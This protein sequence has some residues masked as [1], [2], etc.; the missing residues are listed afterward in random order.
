MCVNILPEVNPG[1]TEG[2]AWLA[3]TDE[4]VES[5]EP[6]MRQGLSLYA[7]KDGDTTEGKRIVGL[8]EALFPQRF[9]EWG[10]TLERAQLFAESFLNQ[11]RPAHKVRANAS[12]YSSV[13]S[14]AVDLMTA[15]ILLVADWHNGKLPNT[16]AGTYLLLRLGARTCEEKLLS[17]VFGDALTGKNRYE[18]LGLPRKQSNTHEAPVYFQDLPFLL[19]G[20]RG[21]ELSAAARLGMEACEWAAEG[22][23]TWS[24]ELLGYLEGLTDSGRSRRFEG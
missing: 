12:R 15:C 7:N 13:F 16:L 18:I 8:L 24:D 9:E 11:Y 14:Q 23:L 19:P 10:L 17:G 3:I 5:L 21:T 1:R 4:G 20:E 6:K 22:N 2:G